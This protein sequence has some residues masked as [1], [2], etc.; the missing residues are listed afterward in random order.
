ML[1]IFI[2]QSKSSPVDITVTPIKPQSNIVEQNVKNRPTRKI[3]I[4][5]SNGNSSSIIDNS[6]KICMVNKS[7]VHIDESVQIKSV[8]IDNEDKAK[9]NQLNSPATP[10]NPDLST[11]AEANITS[12]L[13][14]NMVNPIFEEYDAEVF[15]PNTIDDKAEI[16]K[17]ISFAIGGSKETGLNLISQSEHSITN[18]DA[19]DS[20]MIN[21]YWSETNSSGKRSFR[22]KP[23]DLSDEGSFYVSSELVVDEAGIIDLVEFSGEIH[24]LYNNNIIRVGNKKY[25]LQALETKAM[26]ETIVAYGK[27]LL[28]LADGGL[29]YLYKQ[30]A[31]R[32]SFR[33]IDLQNFNEIVNINVPIIRIGMGPYLLIQ[34]EKHLFLFDHDGVM[35]ERLLYLST[36][37]RVYGKSKDLYV[38]IDLVSN[39]AKLST[40]RIRFTNVIDAIISYTTNNLVPITIE[41]Q[42]ETGFISIRQINGDIYFLKG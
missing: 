30:R 27:H 1:V 31:N 37:K 25:R 42:K 4:P 7:K 8:S 11:F 3:V 17:G 28:A 12:P 26:F 2:P 23:F 10:I 38:D 9:P 14:P 20:S 5:S 21:S 22:D 41:R 19:T 36:H 16:S 18:P 34:T 29:Y 6:S 24:Y 35:I 39:V 15:K 32:W 40:S 13:T 33:R